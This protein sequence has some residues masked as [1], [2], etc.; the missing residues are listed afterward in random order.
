MFLNA[1]NH[2]LT[3]RFTLF[4]FKYFFELLIVLYFFMFCIRLIKGLLIHI[5]TWAKEALD[6]NYK[7]IY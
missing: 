3:G 1:T 4:L 2:T 5:L 6:N 7:I